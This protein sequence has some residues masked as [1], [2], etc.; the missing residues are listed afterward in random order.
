MKVILVL[1]GAVLLVVPCAYCTAGES[2]VNLPFC[3]LPNTQMAIETDSAQA[4]WKIESQSANRAV[5]IWQGHKLSLFVEKSGV[6][7]LLRFR[8]DAPRGKS[9]SV[10]SYAARIRA[11]IAN[12]HAVVCPNAR[13]IAQGD[14]YYKSQK[15][16]ADAPPL[17]HCLIPASFQEPANANCDA[18][19][20]IITDNKG[21]S[22]ISAGWTKANMCGVLAGS[23]EGETYVISLTRRNDIPF[24]G[25]SLED[26]LIITTVPEFW[27]DVVRAYAKAFDRFNG[28]SRKPLPAWTTEP[29]FDTWYCFGDRINQDRVVNTARKCAEL[30]FG[31]MLIDAG[32]DTPSGNGYISFEHGVLGDHFA[33]RDRFPDLPGAVKQM[34]DMGLKV[35]LWCAPFWQGKLSWAYRNVTGDWHLQTPDGEHHSLCPRYPKMPGY[36]RERFAWLAS[37]Y[38]VD[39]MWLDSADNIPMQCVAKHDHV[40]KPMGE[41]FMECMSAARA[42]LRSVNPDSV[43]EVRPLHGNL[44]SKIAFD[45]IQPSDATD[46]LDTQRLSTTLLRAWCYDAQVK[47]DPIHWG[48]TAGP[49]TVGK[50]MA[51]TICMGVPAL[52][53]DFLNATDEQLK[54]TKAWLD[55]YR[56]HK[57][58]LLRGTFRPCGAAYWN[59]DLMFV[60]RDE[61]I[62][63]LRNPNTKEI[64]VP[65][66]VRRVIVFNCTELDALEIAISPCSGEY[67]AQSY[68]PDWSTSGEAAKLAA[69]GS[70]Q[71]SQPVPQGGA[72]VIERT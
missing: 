45:L 25:P 58:T 34:H 54:I 42:G 35:E 29:V 14:A 19:F 39:G 38:K 72:V 13:G 8:L 1:L 46:K 51:T 15:N 56:A 52:S 23:A 48:K 43:I 49:A 71:L 11:P 22:A 30:G 67:R 6:Q 16:W 60:G 18:P 69:G 41:A 55:F 21:N 7:Q 28:R 31:T 44:N 57:D 24:T 66:P 4:E 70:A 63:Y 12:L 32:W 62:V 37:T 59:P 33:Q 50:F 26:T 20:I 61:A 53:V 64:A 47:S 10:S 65:R 68:S 17:Y 27:F 5:Y 9:L 40:G 3:D 36:L 2:V